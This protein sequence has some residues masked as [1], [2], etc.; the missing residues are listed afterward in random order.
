ERAP[1]G[2]R[3]VGDDGVQLA[4]AHDV[5]VRWEIRVLGPLELER[6]AVR[7]RPEAV[8]AEELL[9]L[10]A[11]AHVVELADRP[12]REPVSAC[13]L[14]RELLALDDEHAVPGAPEPVAGRGAGGTPADHER[15]PA[16]SGHRACALVIQP[17]AT[18]HRRAPVL[19]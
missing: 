13:L 3:A 8:E 19:Q 9:E 14:P 6:D 16:R 2:D 5:A 18:S 10:W 4:A 1:G 11:E 15:V 17:V 12:R 7:D